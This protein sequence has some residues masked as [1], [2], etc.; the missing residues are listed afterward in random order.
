MKIIV[1]I[2]FGYETVLIPKIGVEERVDFILEKLGI[3][4]D[5]C[6]ANKSK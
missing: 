6:S 3:S 4:K 5:S 1:L 2:L